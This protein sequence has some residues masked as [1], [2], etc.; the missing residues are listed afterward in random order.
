VTA[1]SV[2]NAAAGVLV[3]ALPLPR[4]I[5]VVDIG[6]NPIDGLPPYKPLLELGI[7][8]LT[9][10]EPHPEA[11]AELIAAA[12]PDEAYLPY[13]VGDGNAHTLHICQAS[14]M[15]SLLAPDPASLA[16][17]N[18][19]AAWGEVVRTVPVATRRLDDIAEVA[20]VDF[21]KI[22]VQGG[23][24]AVFRGGCDKLRQA[25]AIHTEVS[26]VTLYAGQPPFGAVDLELRALG[27][28]PHAFAAVNRRAIAPVVVDNDIYKGVNQLM[29]ADVVY[30]RDIRLP[31]QLSDTQLKTLALI[32]QC[33]YGSFDLAIRCLSI[34]VERGAAS[35][36]TIDAFVRALTPPQ[37]PSG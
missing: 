23:E 37:R 30:V 29:E 25:V 34:L 22:D 20:E 6:A 11:F 14:G 19:F 4:P 5:A 12:R 16:L 24:L 28:L 32:A 31:A 26:F 21:L 15:T 27:F 2:P 3:N 13:A 10:F 7:A 1:D 36:A 9:G 17:F 8:R 18:G 35:A 33:S